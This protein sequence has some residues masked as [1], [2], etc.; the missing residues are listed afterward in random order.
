MRILAALYT[1]NRLRPA[2]LT[3]SLK[4]FLEASA[5]GPVT[6][7]VSSWQPIPDLTCPNLIS[8]FKI[9]E[10]GHLNILLQLQQIIHTCNEP[11][12]YFAFC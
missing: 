4:F 12:D 1:H 11:W 10:H 7:I 2:L 3:Q 8:H 6:P 9:A 5:N